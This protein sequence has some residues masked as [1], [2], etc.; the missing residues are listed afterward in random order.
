MD[1]NNLALNDTP[2]TL[3]RNEAFA[4]GNNCSTYA[5]VSALLAIHEVIDTT[6][7][8]QDRTVWHLR[9]S[10]DPDNVPRS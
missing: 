6:A 7:G 4:I 9:T 3:L 5:G 10:E 1:M 8:P 2:N